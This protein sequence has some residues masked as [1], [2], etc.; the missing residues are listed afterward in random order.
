MRR[1]GLRSISA[2]GGG[3]ANGTVLVTGGAMGSG[4]GVRITGPLSLLK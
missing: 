3:D 2:S 1:S 4:A